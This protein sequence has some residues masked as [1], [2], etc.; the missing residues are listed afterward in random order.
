MLALA[1]T[2]VRKSAS[3]ATSSVVVTVAVESPRVRCG[4]M[5]PTKTQPDGEALN[6]LVNGVVYDVDGKV[7]RGNPAG[8]A[9]HRSARE[10]AVVKRFR[11]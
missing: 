10:I 2:I 6:W 5:E 1:F 11:C 4:W 8:L 3:E 7:L 9:I